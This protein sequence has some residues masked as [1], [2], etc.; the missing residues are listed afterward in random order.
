MIERDAYDVAQEIRMERQTHKG[1]FIILEGRNDQKS[2]YRHINETHCSIVVAGSKDVA[3]ESLQMLD[4]DGYPGIVCLVDS[5]FEKSK[6]SSENI[7]ETN[8][9]DMD[10]VIFCSPALDRYL[11]ERSNPQKLKDFE[12]SVAMSIRDA[13]FK[14]AVPIACLRVL[15]K[16]L[17]LR[18]NFSDINFDFVSEVDISVDEDA[19]FDSII[20]PGGRHD[21]EDVRRRY[22]IIKRQNHPRDLL[23]QGHDLMTILGI[24]LRRCIADVRNTHRDL[25]DARTWRSEVEMGC[26]LAFGRDEFEATSV[27]KSISEWEERNSPYCVLL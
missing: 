3:I 16:N 6:Y 9:H 1:A 22:E 21:R 10:V 11:F 15:S 5:D 7:I 8:V 14:A 19:M 12:E 20:W 27:Y 2:L 24:A 26:R 25:P 13:L 17:G 23:C 18:L 4:D